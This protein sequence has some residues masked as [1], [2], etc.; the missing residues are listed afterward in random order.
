MKKSLYPLA[1]TSIAL[2]VGFLFASEESKTWDASPKAKQFVKDT[3]VIDMFASPHGTGW[4]EDSHFHDYLKRARGAGITGSEM[5]LA[6]GSYTF[7][8][9]LNEHYQYRRVMAQTP[10]KYVFVRSVRDIEYAHKTGK[11]AV[12]WNSQTASI[13]DGDLKKIP[14]LKEIGLA[15]IILSYNDLFRTG[16]GGLAEDVTEGELNFF[17]PA[18]RA[19]VAMIAE[20][21][22]PKTDTPGATEA[23]VPAWIE[24]IVKDCFEEADQRIIIDGLADL[25]KRCQEQH[26]KSIDQLSGKQQVAFLNKMNHET[27]TEKKKRA[28]KEGWQRRTFLEQFKDLTKLCYCSSEV[29][30]TQAFEYHLIPGKWVPSMPLEPGQKAWAM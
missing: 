17:R 23:G 29:G 1:L 25:A 30:A 19:Q 9:F 16:S 28:K 13:I 5:T 8:Q 6:A 15:S 18:Q 10:D 20:A 26:G 3:I 22:I 14:L 2:A 24:V 27:Q 4:T 12:V 21:I 7:D 11:T